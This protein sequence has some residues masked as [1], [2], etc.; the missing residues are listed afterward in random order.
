[1]M[2]NILV[3]VVTALLIAGLF[4]YLSWQKKQRF[5]LLTNA[6]QAAG[7]Q[8]EPIEERLVSGVLING[9]NTHGEWFLETKATASTTDAGPGSSETSLHTRWWTS[10]MTLPEGN[11]L[12]GPRPP[13]SQ[14]MGM[15]NGALLQMAFKALL[16]KDADWVNDLLPVE[17]VESTV[18]QR[19]L[20]LANSKED[21]DRLMKPDATRLL[22]LLPDTI[23]PVIKLRDTGLEI[24][25]PGIRLEKI[26]DI[27][28]LVDL[29]LNLVDSWR[30]N[31]AN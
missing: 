23:K 31:Y 18:N 2:M 7:W 5:A 27:Q 29:G 26:E 3:I 9:R 1:M 30:D 16:G 4:V 8:I 12:I 13:G 10:A 25:L 28:A 21:A 15:V 20:C 17:L 19:Y 6:A 14:F 11:L 24:A 22:L